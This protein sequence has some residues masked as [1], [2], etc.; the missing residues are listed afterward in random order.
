[1]N[2]RQLAAVARLSPSAVSLALRDSPKISAATKRRVRQLAE[3][4][5]YRADAKVVAMMMHLRKPRA[6]R[7]QA[8]FG[9]IS[10]YD[11]PHPWERSLHLT[12]IYD[13]MRRRAD[14]L[15]YR[16]EPVWLRAP[17]MTYRRVRGVLDARGI[18]GLLCF[19]SPDLEQEFP[20][21]LA[22]YAIVT[23]GLSIRTPLHRVTS[24]FYDDTV[25]ALDRLHELGYR[26]PGLVLGRYEEIRGGHAHTSA[27]LGWCEHRLGAGRALPIHLVDHVEERPLLEWL[28]RERP[29]ALI[30]VH[31]Y[32]RL[33]ELRTVLRRNRIRLPAD[34]GVA[35]LSQILEGSGFS[36]L[37]QNQPLMGAWAVELLAA[38]IANRDLGIPANPRTEMVGGQWIENRSLRLQ[39]GRPSAFAH[40][41]GR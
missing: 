10:F 12:R 26:R 3:K 2:L 1:M 29:D 41:G 32:D 34:L 18:E 30:F 37:Q 38:R 22:H 35:A 20:A 31:L 15:G 19:G 25:Q 14:E 36:G 5:G 33:P 28:R 4:H 24:H 27:Y 40:G 7:Q 39:A 16:L 13:G 17:G 11:E 21:E 9:V 8:C 6:V 23:I